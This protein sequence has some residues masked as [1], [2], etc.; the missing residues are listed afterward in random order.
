MTMLERAPDAPPK[1]TGPRRIAVVPVF[2]EEPTVVAVLEELMT[3]VDE[4][5][6]VDDGSVDRSREVILEWALGRQHVHTILFNQ[7]QGLSAAY[8]AAFREI[9][10]RLHAGE[11]DP[12]DL[13]ITVDADG[14]HDPA[15]LDRLTARVTEDGFDAAVAR[16]DMSDYSWVKRLGNASLSLWASLW[17]GTRLYDVES[18]F[19]VFRA[20]PLVEALK[21]Y[22]GYRYSETVEV[23]V[24]LP[25]LGYTIAND[26]SVPVPVQRSRTRISDGVIDALAM[27]G[28]WWRVVAGRHRPA[29]MPAWSIYVVP[30]LALLAVL[31][32]AGDILAHSLFL[33]SDS[34]HNYAHVWYLSDQIFHHG[35]IPLHIS[36]LDSG[37]AVTFPYAIAPYLAGALLYPVLGNWAVSLLMAVAVVG[38]VWA[39][40]V[41]RPAMRDPWLIALF[42]LNPFFIDAAFGFQFAS[43]W[44]ALFFFLFVRACEKQMAVPAAVLLWLSVSSQPLMGTLAAGAYGLAILVL[45]RERF[46]RLLAIGVPVGLALVPIYWMTLMTPSLSDS[47]GAFVRT[48]ISSV[49][50][51]GT[52]F[53]APFIVSAGA[54]YLRRYYR[55]M[56]VFSLSTAIV[57]VLL[58]GG[59]VRYYRS[60][61]GYYGVFHASSDVYAQYFDSP[62]FQAGATYRVLEPSEREDGMYRFIQHRAVLS[63]EFF[64]ESTMHRNWN[65]DQYGCY[66]A[67]KGIDYVV[68]EKVWQERN[69]LNEGQLLDSLVADGKASVSYS[70]PAGRFVVYNIQPFVSGQQKPSSLSECSL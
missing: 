53:A 20:G 62:S 36:L 64:T 11:L 16:R 58:L 41:V 49:L 8:F 21:Y 56:L 59:V 48:T 34:M 40:G 43:L 44:S 45:H 52:F 2:N 37:K 66:A 7:N 28:A 61:S 4:V 65:A 1:A 60:P 26:V 67:Y 24:V 12:G 30:V 55:P 47:T 38:T 39:A 42:V 6:V 63:N 15:D 13:V 3:L 33:A 57:G 68:V 29:D 23:A 27:I 31:F 32:I 19:R 17:A 35:S 10:A 70:D 51:R 18:G 54:P 69:G 50:T 9:G 5:V 14:Q 46:P 25:R 22:H